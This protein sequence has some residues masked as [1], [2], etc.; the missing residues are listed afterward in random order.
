MESN[1]AMLATMGAVGGLAMVA[2]IKKLLE[3]ESDSE[4]ESD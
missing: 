3:E 2:I 4:E 1:K